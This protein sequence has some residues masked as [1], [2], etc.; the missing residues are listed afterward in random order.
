MASIKR[1]LPTCDNDCT[2]LGWQESLF[3]MDTNSFHVSYHPET[4]VTKPFMGFCHDTQKMMAFNGP[5]I[6]HFERI[7]SL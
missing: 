5:C 6:E 1:P 7:I 4:D 2:K 3:I